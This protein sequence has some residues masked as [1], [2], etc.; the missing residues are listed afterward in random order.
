MIKWDS[1]Q[2]C[3]IFFNSH[4]SNNVIHH[5]NK[6]KNENHM[7][8][9]TDAEKS[10]VK[11]QYPCMIN[12]PK[13]DIAVTYLNITKAIQ[14]KPIAITILNGEKLKA[15]SVRSG[16]RQGY[17]LS[18]LQHS[19]G[20]IALAI[21]EEKEVKGLQTGKEVQLSLFADE[22]VCRYI[23]DPTDSAR[24]LLELSEFGK[25]SGHKIN[26][27]Y[28]LYFYKLTERSEIEIRETIPFTIISFVTSKKNKMGIKLP[29]KTCS[30]GDLGLIS[31][32]RR[33][34]EKGMAAHSIL[35]WR[36]P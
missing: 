7:I 15:F 6:L 13:M 32:W 23:E 8:I 16:K 14:D 18:P 27:Q 26:T 20:I 24:K 21:R 11:L 1:S 25:F 28:L 35:D 19:F 2:G 12:T 17:L 30:A 34:L 29:K 33:S 36:I 10:F 9:S 4:K 22:T 3:Q 31:G 5:I